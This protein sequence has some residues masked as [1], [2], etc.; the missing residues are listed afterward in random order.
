MYIDVIA[1]T[2]KKFALDALVQPYTAVP[3]PPLESSGR[4]EAPREPGDTFGGNTITSSLGLP[5]V[6]VPGGYT[7]DNLPI[8]IQFFG[9][10]FDD[11]TVLKVA[12][13]YE[14]S[15]RRRKTPEST[16]PL[17]GEHFEY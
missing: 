4:D 15:S 12:Y 16:P 7:A 6:V 10:P 13:G 2:M 5:A 8:A 9:K 14:Q 11:L 1:D 17:S 3:A